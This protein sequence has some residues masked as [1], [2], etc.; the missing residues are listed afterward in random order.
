MKKYI[1]ITILGILTWSCTE[2]ID[3]N[4]DDQKYARIVV[5]GGIST[6]TGQHVITLTKTANYFD[7]QPPAAVSGAQVTIYNDTKEYQLTEDPNK[8]G[9]YL[10]DPDV[11]GV[12][13]NEYLMDIKLS[14]EVGG[15]LAYTSSSQIYPVNQLDSIALEF[16]EDWGDDG[17]YEVK[18][19][20]WDSPSVD[21][22]MFY[23]YKNGIR[24]NDTIT[25]VFVVDDLLYNGNYTNG[26]GVGYLDQSMDHQKLNPGDTVT[27]QVARITKEYCYYLWDVQLEVSYQSPLFS[28]PPANVKGNISDG[29]FGFFAAY[30]STY[31]STILE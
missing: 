14:E 19:Y 9:D 21:Y 7:N 24:V 23:V 22:Y 3:I 12:V 26:I 6:D 15:Q 27:L 20:V 10:T 16:H 4:L 17:Y 2:K 28:G 5:E 1:I 13:G 30:S 31:A 29:G 25:D 11:Y 18:C 8:P